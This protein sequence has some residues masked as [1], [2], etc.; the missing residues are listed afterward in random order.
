MTSGG[1]LI[2]GEIHDNAAHHRLQAAA[3]EEFA[4][5]VSPKRPPV[6]FEQLR[7]DQ[8][9]GLESFNALS[10]G[11]TA[12]K[13]TLDDLKRLVDWEK[14]SWSKHIYDP[15]FS[16]AIANDLPIH[17][18]DVARVEIRKAAKDGEAAL[19]PE[20]R[21][22]LGLDVS[23]EESLDAASIKEIEASHCGALPKTAFGGMAFAQR[24]RDAHLADAVLNAAASGGSAFLIAGNGHARTDRGVPWYL[25]QRAPGKPVVSVMF[26]EV[27]DGK[28]DPQSYVPRGPDGLPAADFI[29]FTERSE[30][31]DPCEM[32]RK[33]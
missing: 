32:M 16:A 22:Q 28:T 14:T 29:V 23:L 31:G 7:A 3:V 10:A 25:R 26:V 33:K 13:G 30:R 1:V 12:K 2:L 24:Y 4:R 19:A 6:V 20:L 27:E 5:D 17:A 11:A 18:G 21:S 8:K 9:A 15:L